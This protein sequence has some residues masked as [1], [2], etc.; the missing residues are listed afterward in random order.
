MRRSILLYIKQTEKYR[1]YSLVELNKC[2]FYLPNRTMINEIDILHESHCYDFTRHACEKPAGLLRVVSYHHQIVIELG[3]YGF[4]SFSESPVSSRRRSPI[5]LIHPLWNL[6]SNVRRLKEV[7]SDFGTEIPLVSEH[8]A[9]AIFPTDI[10]E[11]A[12]V[13]DACGCHAI[14]MYDPTYSAYSMEFMPITARSPRCATS[15]VGSGVDIVTPHRAAFRP[16]VPTYLDRPGV[17]TEHV[18]EAVNGGSHVPADFLRE[19]DRQLAADIELPAAD[20]VRQF[21][22][23]FIAQTIKKEILTVEPGSLRRYAESY[24]LQVGKLLNSTASGD[25]PEFVYTIF[26]EILA[27]LEDSDEIC[28]KVAHKQCDGT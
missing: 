4:Y 12:D 1:I 17:N 5:F 23:A 11:I 9:V 16:G 18:P 28:H 26:G 27:Y 22:P 2:I 13:M 7:L 15:I 6:K 14:G 3:E 20:Q 19:A 25:V 10:T 8:Q 24:D 21:I